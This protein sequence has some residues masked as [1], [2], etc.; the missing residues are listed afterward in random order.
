M[1]EDRV[2]ALWGHLGDMSA[3]EIKAHIRKLRADRR[4]IKAKNSVKKDSKQ[5]SD[6]ARSRATKLAA[7]MD[8]EALARM[9][10]DLKS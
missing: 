7:T 8:P 1:S 10:R 5:K 6:G 3:D 2:E 9:L 4:L